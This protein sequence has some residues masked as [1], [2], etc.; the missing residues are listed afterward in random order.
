MMCGSES[1]V[2][3]KDALNDGFNKD[4][5]FYLSLSDN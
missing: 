1:I 2:I 5:Y 3:N 4:N